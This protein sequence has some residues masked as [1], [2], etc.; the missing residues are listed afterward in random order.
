MEI[1][2][3]SKGFLGQERK[4][5]KIHGLGRNRVKLYKHVRLVQN[6]GKGAYFQENKK[7][8][9]I[10]ISFKLADEDYFS[11]TADPPPDYLMQFTLTTIGCHGNLQWPQS[12]SGKIRK[13]KDGSW[14][15]QR[16]N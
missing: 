7:N 4:S 11:S 2:A 6:F 9:Q 14:I 8:N 5:K 12:N 3:M 15:G 13:I 16:M 1:R 10:R